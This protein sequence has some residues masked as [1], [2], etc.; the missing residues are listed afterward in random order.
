MEAASAV[1]VSMAE[2]ATAAERRPVILR[3]SDQGFPKDLDLSPGA[4]E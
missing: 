1:V 4:S 2:A 3:Q